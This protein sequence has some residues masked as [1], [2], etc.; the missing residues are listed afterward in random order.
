M[1]YPMPTP[2]GT[3]RTDVPH[4]FYAMNREEIVQTLIG[5]GY[6][7]KLAERDADNFLGYR[8]GPT[9][10]PLEDGRNDS[11]SEKEPSNRFADAL[12]R[13]FGRTGEKDA[14]EHDT[15]TPAASTQ[16]DKTVTDSAT[17]RGVLDRIGDKL[18]RAFGR[19][20]ETDNDEHR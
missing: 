4:Q 19:R 1:R 12:V 18:E 5:Y 13:A 2:R 9:P 6:T 11:V 8:D 16:D 14:P 3:R 10:S 17:N 15:D 20:A 7:R